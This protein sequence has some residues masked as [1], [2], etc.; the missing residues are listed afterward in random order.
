MRTRVRDYREDPFPIDGTFEFLASF[1][2]MDENSVA[3]PTEDEA[4][5]GF[6]YEEPLASYHEKYTKYDR[7]GPLSFER[8]VYIKH[9]HFILPKREGQAVTVKHARCC[10]Y[11]MLLKEF[12]EKVAKFRK[13]KQFIE[14]TVY[15]NTK[16]H[17]NSFLVIRN[18]YCKELADLCWDDSVELAVP[19]AKGKNKQD[20]D[21]DMTRQKW[22]NDYGYTSGVNLTRKDSPT[23]VAAPFL[24]KTHGKAN[25]VKSFCAVSEYV[26]NLKMP[27]LPANVVPFNHND[28]DDPRNALPKKIHPDNII[29]SMRF[30]LTT[31]G[32]PCCCHSDTKN[33]Q[34]IAFESVTTFAMSVMHENEEKHMAMIA[35]SRC[36]IDQCLVCE[37]VYAPY[38]K[39]ICDTYNSFDNVRK[40]LCADW[41]KGGEVIECVPGLM[42]Y[43]LPCHLD[44]WGMY[45]AWVHYT[46]LLRLQF[47]LEDMEVTSLVRAMAV[48]PQCTYYYGAAA[49]AVLQEKTIDARHRVGG[50][51]SFLIATLLVTIHDLLYAAKNYNVAPTRYSKYHAYVLPDKEV[52]DNDCTRMN[53]RLI[54]CRKEVMPRSAIERAKL[55][56]ETRNIL[57]NN[58]PA[59]DFLGGNHLCGLLATIKMLP[60]WYAR[61]V[62]MRV[63]DKPVEWLLQ[64]YIEDKKKRTKE[65]VITYMAHI[66]A[67]LSTKF[68]RNFDR[69]QVENILCKVFRVAGKSK[70][71]DRFKDIVFLGQPLYTVASGEVV[72]VAKG[73]DDLV[74]TS[75]ELH[76]ND[77]VTFR[78]KIPKSRNEWLSGLFKMATFSILNME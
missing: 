34:H 14:M 52:W 69:R 58:L 11:Q 62:D 72:L 74:L 71:D 15:E 24:R 41:V 8:W 53:D 47:S 27:W 65:H 54:K 49:T 78:L 45:S 51:F 5:F 50:N 64:T 26:K 17:S 75:S 32:N 57:V 66:T 46:N 30:A 13:T 12:L 22:Y 48:I 59:V 1:D 77:K 61:E 16:D 35:F 33:S 2:D 4:S 29:P 55:Y 18:T 73:D 63:S 42:A 37:A 76:E 39:F 19:T 23:G 25:L 38:V 56:T 28:N 10:H 7:Y 36:A 20:K 43:S 44:P 60:I 31:S 9:L 70:S 40:N 68:G 67:G 3:T 21:S 6:V